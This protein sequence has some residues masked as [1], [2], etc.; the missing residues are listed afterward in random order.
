[1]D[2][3]LDALTNVVGI[4]VIVLVAVQISSQEAAKRMEEMFKKVDPKE[5]Q[6]IAQQ[7]EEAKAKIEQVTQE[8]AR[9]KQ[10]EKIDPEKLLRALK[11]DIEAAEKKAKADRLAAQ[12]AERAAEKA[13][14]EAEEAKKQLAMRLISLEKKSE[15]L[16]ASRDDLTVQLKKTPKVIAPKGLSVRPPTPGTGL[17]MYDQST[18]NKLLDR[19]QV[20]VT[21]GRAIPWFDNGNA[22]RKLVESGIAKVAASLN[23]SFDP[24]NRVPDKATAEKI[25]AAFNALPEN[26][27]ELPWFV[28]SLRLAGS[29]LG[30]RFTLKEDAGETPEEAMRGNFAS[31]FRNKQRDWYIQYLVA[32]DSFEEYH[33]FRS[34]TD[35]SQFLA[36]WRPIAEGDHYLDTGTKFNFGPKPPPRPNT[37]PR[38]RKPGEVTSDVD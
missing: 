5:V 23:L 12:D 19:R 3:L 14:L 8:I 20:L 28:I 32:P 22:A 9:E 24:D 4:L 21:R 29:N 30:I 1:M 15:E 2:S 25:V 33:L 7:A 27:R 6:K 38:P 10:Q 26:Q 36:G 18:G 11:D 37:P 34:M 17:M 35:R 16:T 31:T 13:R